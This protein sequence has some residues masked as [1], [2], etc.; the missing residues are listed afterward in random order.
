MLRA[1]IE[2]EKLTIKALPIMARFCQSNYPM[3][4]RVEG[5]SWESP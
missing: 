1:D 2:N 5:G 3:S 4:A